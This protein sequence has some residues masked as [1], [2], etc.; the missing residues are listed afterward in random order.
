MKI[1]AAVTADK[2][3]DALVAHLDSP[4]FCVELM[5]RVLGN[6]LGAKDPCEHPAAYYVQT[7][8][9]S[10]QIG[11]NLCG[12]EV[13]LTGASVTPARTDAAFH[14]ALRTMRE[15]YAIA[16]REKV[17]AGTRV[18]LFVAIMV[19]GHVRNSE[20]YSVSVIEAGPEWLEGQAS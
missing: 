10:V 3:L 16:I 6:A 11:Q 20:G 17:P 1:K 19:D 9:R 14:D 15:M 4:H 7:T 2:R 18:E 5:E 12:V 13:R 8:D